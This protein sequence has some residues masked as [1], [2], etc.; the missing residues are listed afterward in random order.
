M[1]VNDGSED[2]C[3]GV[4]IKGINRN[5]IHMSSE[6]PRDVIPTPTWGTHGRNEE[7]KERKGRRFLRERFYLLNFV[8]QNKGG[9]SNGCRNT[10]LKQLLRPI[11]MRANS[12]INQS[13][14][15]TITCNLLKAREKSRV[16]GAIGCCLCFS[17]VEKLARV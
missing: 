8:L 11:L 5:D 6:P 2:L 12:A 14:F 4:V 17:L 1:P 7:L 9:F 3:H 15:L 13:E 16:Y 10:K